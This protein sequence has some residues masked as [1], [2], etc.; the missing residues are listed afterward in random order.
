MDAFDL[1][2]DIAS[3]DYKLALSA[4]LLAMLWTERDDTAS[5]LA[6]GQALGRLLLSACTANIS[7]AFFNQPIEVAKMRTELAGLMRIGGFPQIL[8]RLGYGPKMRATSRR[9]V[10][11]V[12]M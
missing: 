3:K 10:D 2:N 7:A 4:P 1:S 11:E 5:W 12:L 9:R 6:A 8:L